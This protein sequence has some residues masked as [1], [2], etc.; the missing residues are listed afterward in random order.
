MASPFGAPPALATG[1]PPK[2]KTERRRAFRSSAPITLTRFILK[3]N[4]DFKSA[5]GGFSML[6]QSIQLACKVIASSASLSGIANNYGIQGDNPK[7]LRAATP[8]LNEFANDVFIN[9]LTFSEQVYVMGS[10]EVKEPI[11]VD[12][13]SGGYAV[14]FDPL[15]GANNVYANVS[16]GTVFGIYKKAEKSSKVTGIEDLMRPG[17]Q[18]ICAGYALY[19]S[20]TMLVLSTGNGVNGF[21]LDPTI[22]EF[23]LTHRN[24]R[25]P[26]Q[27]KIYSI[28][29]GNSLEWNDAT[30]HMVAKWKGIGGT[31]RSLRYIGSM[32]SDIHRTMLYG[33]VFCY[34]G[35]KVN[36][37]GKLRLLYELN[38]VAFLI[39]QAGGRA[40]TGT[41]RVLDVVPTSLHHQ[42]PIF[43]GSYDDVLEV[44]EAYRRFGGSKL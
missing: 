42:Q 39:E 27:G 2:P 24:I 22:G 14:V 7:T 33:G 4:S 3:N 30:R 34:P 18:L 29:E 15:D 1:S 5:T 41:Q 43:C 8:D 13:Y 32:V 20:A 19:G 17:N 44:E 6:L 36:K 21:S 12:Q 31:P 10:E 35:D 16:V 25:I 26:K 28:N 40:T 38:P 37:N 23:I 11:V 9:C